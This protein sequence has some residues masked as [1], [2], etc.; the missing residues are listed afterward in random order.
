MQ[1]AGRELILKVIMPTNSS[2]KLPRGDIAPGNFKTSN[3]D[4]CCF[5]KW[6]QLKAILTIQGFK[7]LWNKG[8]EETL[9]VTT[10]IEHKSDF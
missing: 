5:Y 8:R 4:R 10:S 9:L 1:I 6:L 7:N 3:R 2:R